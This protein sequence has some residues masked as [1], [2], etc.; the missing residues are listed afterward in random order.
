MNLQNI[1]MVKYAIYD[2]PKWRTPHQATA[3]FSTIIRLYEFNMDSIL[4]SGYRKSHTELI[5]RVILG[6]NALF[7]N[8]SGWKN[9]K[10]IVFEFWSFSLIFYERRIAKDFPWILKVDENFSTRIDSNYI[11]LVYLMPCYQNHVDIVRV[12]SYY[13]WKPSSSQGWG[14]RQ[15]GVSYIAYLTIA[16]NYMGKLRYIWINVTHGT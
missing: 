10:D 1:D 13:G 3:R 12:K 9:E 6:Y 4:I 14:V 15:F 7:S 16:K 2:T 11:V 8:I 5:F